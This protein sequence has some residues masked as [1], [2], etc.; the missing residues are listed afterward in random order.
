M[1]TRDGESD[2]EDM[3]PGSNSGERVGPNRLA[4]AIRSQIVAGRNLTKRGTNG[5]RE[6]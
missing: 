4:A 2:E 5:Q 3:N 6:E 1:A